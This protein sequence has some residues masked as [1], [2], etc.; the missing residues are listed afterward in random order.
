M[1]IPSSEKRITIT[2][3]GEVFVEHDGTRTRITV[4]PKMAILLSAAFAPIFD[5]HCADML[6][7]LEGEEG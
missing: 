7:K 6:L 1:N 4:D 3:E 5:D 2:E